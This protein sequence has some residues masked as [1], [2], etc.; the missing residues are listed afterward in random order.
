MGAIFHV[1][2]KWTSNWPPW[3]PAFERIACWNIERRSLQQRVSRNS[4]VIC[5][6]RSPGVPETTGAFDVT[7]FTIAGGGA[8]D[9]LNLAAAVNM[10]VYELNRQRVNLPPH[11]CPQEIP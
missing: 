8:I 2:W 1:P 10:C 9:V 4:S 7:P 3:P 5:W 6:Q 11:L